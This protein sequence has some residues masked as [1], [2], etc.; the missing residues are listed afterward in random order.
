MVQEIRVGNHK[1]YCDC[2]ETATVWMVSGEGYCERCIKAGYATRLSEGRAVTIYGKGKPKWA[3]IPVGRN[4]LGEV[5][6]VMVVRIHDPMTFSGP[7][8]LDDIWAVLQGKPPGASIRRA[9]RP[10]GTYAEFDASRGDDLP[11]DDWG[12]A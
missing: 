10:P 11:A 8:A 6:S 2:G 3:L 1:Q 7:A 4:E 9:W 5:E 12:E